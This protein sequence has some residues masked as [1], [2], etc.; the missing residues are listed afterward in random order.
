MTAA[1][2]HHCE[3]MVR[4]ADK[5]RFLATLFAPAEHRPA[6]YALYAF[7]IEI[8]RIRDLAREPMPGEIRLQWWREVVEGGRTEEAQAHPVAAAL[9][10]AMTRYQLSPEV[11]ADLID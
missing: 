1:A 10:A 2:D 8:N 7:N 3:S 5:D 11:F 9:R 6:L 4:E